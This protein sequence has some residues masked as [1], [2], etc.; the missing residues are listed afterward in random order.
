MLKLV[1]RRK[2]RDIVAERIKEHIT[3][4][5][6]KP[7]DRLPTEHSLAEQLGVSR[8]SVREATKGLEF[9]GILESR[10]GRGLT[11]GKVDFSRMSECLRFHAGFDDDSG[12][13]LVDARIILETGVLRHVSRRMTK[14]PTVYDRLNAING[15]LRQTRDLSQFIALDIDFHRLLVES[16]GLAPMAAFNDLVQIFFQ[17]FRESVKRAEWKDGVDGH[18]KIIDSLRDGA[19]EVASETL[20]RHI[21]CHRGRP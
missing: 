4:M 2:I 19:V 20:C 16:S 14:E 6:L 17:R 18:Q 3:V 21:E 13:Q 10:P 9:L 15:R 11:V 8:V 12:D 7:G 1:E 5:R